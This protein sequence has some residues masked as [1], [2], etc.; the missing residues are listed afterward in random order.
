M[1]SLNVLMSS[2]SLSSL[3]TVMNDV[4]LAERY[5]LGLHVHLAARIIDQ[6]KYVVVRGI[7][8]ILWCMDVIAIK[9]YVGLSKPIILTVLL[10]SW[11]SIQY[12]YR[13]RLWCCGS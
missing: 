8:N 9:K 2:L 6:I 12:D 10:T 11:I 3:L 5:L 13:C 4:A 1:K 7:Q